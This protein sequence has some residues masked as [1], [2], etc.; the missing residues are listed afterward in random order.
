LPNAPESFSQIY[1]VACSIAS[2]N[3]QSLSAAKK[4][5]VCRAKIHFF[6]ARNLS[7]QT[8]NFEVLSHDLPLLISIKFF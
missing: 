5:A 6:Q 1:R 7:A 4:L 3:L 8:A 2:S